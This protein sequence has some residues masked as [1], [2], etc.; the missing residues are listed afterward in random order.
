VITI[1]RDIPIEEAARIMADHKVG[2]LPVVEGKKV[3]GIVTETNL[4]MVFLEMF[5]ARMPG[6]RL[7]VLIEEEPGSL[8][9]LTGAIH[10][11]G[12]NILA[13]GTF[14]GENTGNRMVVIK[15]AGVEMEALKQAVASSVLRITDIR[16]T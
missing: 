9:Q 16:M 1:T 12:G 13:L 7:T 10:A 15:V 5:A 6:V 14:M 4:F 2:G 8:N 3:V 11:T